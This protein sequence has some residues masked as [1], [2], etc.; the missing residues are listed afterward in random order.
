MFVVNRNIRFTATGLMLTL[1]ALLNAQEGSKSYTVE[2]ANAFFQAKDWESAARAYESIVKQ[3]PSNGQAWLQLGLSYHNLQKYDLAISAYEAAD[4]LQFA[5]ARTHYNLACA[6]SLMNN[7][8][9]AFE[10]L[11]KALEAGFA[12]AQSLE[13]DPDLANLRDDP[14]FKHALEVADKNARPCEYSD[15]HRAFDFWI[16]EWD[17]FNPQ[18]QQVGSN[19]IQKIL[20][21][22]VIYENWTSAR[23][24]YFGKSFNYFAPSIGKWRQNWVDGAGGIVWYEGEVKDGVMHFTG[25]SISMDGSIQLAR[26]TLTP[27]P[28]GRV[29]HV[30]EQSADDGKTWSIYFDGLYV[31]KNTNGSNSSSKRQ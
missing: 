14:R 18:G 24:G 20:N 4:K 27:L 16:G 9:R 3:E 12:Q 6:Y 19:S 21:G 13:G 30:I 15:K 26:V 5:L 29:H 23:S 7:K 31:K 8:E 10:W 25:E 1:A 17:L 2:Q 28:D 11:N 22:C